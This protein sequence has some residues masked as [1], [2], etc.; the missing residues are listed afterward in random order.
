MKSIKV[1]ILV[2]L[3]KLHLKNIIYCITP[4]YSI[5]THIITQSDYIT[6]LKLKTLLFNNYLNRPRI[7]KV[8]S[9]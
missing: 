4:S 3:Q 9:S 6:F 5:Y 2:I 1:L 8:F 7:F